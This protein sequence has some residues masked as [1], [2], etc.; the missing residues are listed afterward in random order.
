MRLRSAQST[1]KHTGNHVDTRCA[2]DIVTFAR[3]HRVGVDRTRHDV[4][5]SRADD[6]VR[7]GP[8]ATFRRARFHRHD[9]RRAFA[10]C[11]AELGQRRLLRVGPA[12]LRVK[13]LRHDVPV[14]HDQR[15]DHRM[16]M[17]G[18]PALPRQLERA[19]HEGLVLLQVCHSERSE[20]SS[21]IWPAES[22]WILRCAQNDRKIL[23]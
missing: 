7:A 9:E 3:M 8:G 2:Q 5:D 21:E 12:V 10:R 22:K 16:R 13:S 14:F 19:P 1:L 20:E 11:A 15:L 4:F 23:C 17:R 6:Q 18:T